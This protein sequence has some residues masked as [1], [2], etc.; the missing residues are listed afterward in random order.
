M[1]KVYN[2]EQALATL[3]AVRDIKDKLDLI[4]KELARMITE[5]RKA[6]QEIEDFF[7]V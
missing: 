3:E 2:E 1:T 5:D 7:S 4:K 6:N